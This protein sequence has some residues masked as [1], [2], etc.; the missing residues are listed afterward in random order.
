LTARPVGS[1]ALIRAQSTKWVVIMVKRL[2]S[3]SRPGQRGGG[4]V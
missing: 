3:V 2:Q 1:L 4:A